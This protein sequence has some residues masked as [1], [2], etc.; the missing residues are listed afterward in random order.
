MPFRSDCVIDLADVC[1]ILANAG[2]AELYKGHVCACTDDGVLVPAHRHDEGYRLE[3]VTVDS[4]IEVTVA[5][6]PREAG[7]ENAVH[8]HPL[9]VTGISVAGAGIEP[10]LLD[11]ALLGSAVL[12]SDPGKNSFTQQ[13]RERY[14]STHGRQT[15]STDNGVTEQ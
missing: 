9:Y 4:I 12:L 8:P 10:A 11:A 13:S 14:S 3:S 7:V 15:G 6:E 1:R 5:G 2:L